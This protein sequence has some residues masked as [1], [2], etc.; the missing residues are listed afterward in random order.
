MKSAFSAAVLALLLVDA[1]AAHACAG[2]S[3]PN[4][5]TGRA[6][7]ILLAPGE[8]S[9]TLGFSATTMSVIHSERCPDIG[10]VCQERDEPPQLH[11]QDFYV[12]ELRPIFELG[13]TR[14]FG[15]EAQ[16]PLRFTRTTV[17]FRRL[18]GEAFTPDYQ[19][20]H[21]RNEDLVGLGDP[22]LSGRAAWRLGATLFNAKMGLTLPVGRIEPDPFAR[23]R[24]GLP[25]QHV[26]Y[27]TGTFNPVLGVDVLSRLG[28]FQWT[29]YGQ[30]ML[31]LY[32][33]RFG[34]QAGNRFSL[35]MA[36]EVAVVE[37]LRL[38][39]SA[40]L[41]NEQPE[42]WSGVVQQDGNVG[43]T[44]ALLGGQMGYRFDALTI[45]FS[46]KAPVWQHFIQ[47]N[48]AHSDEPT[49]LRYPAVV[50]LSLQRTFGE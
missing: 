33:S 27:G 12:G 6:Q 42:R 32:E 44:D 7:A 13:L 29:G 46:V 22:W 36:G 15:I 3:N 31:A 10:P 17:V 4:L 45:L 25:H 2:C 23:G 41:I 48:D 30:T 8:L 35:G 9:A 39:L 26:Q 18:S 47:V 43:R 14:V 1:G 21:H 5:P 28:R 19:N 20:I 11:D 49:Q 50:S 37:R 38:G 34:Y 16:L 40:D 24:A